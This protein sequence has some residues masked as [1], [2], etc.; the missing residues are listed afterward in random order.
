[1]VVLV[2]TESVTPDFVVVIDPQAIEREFTTT[3][4]SFVVMV[5]SAH[6]APVVKE[7]ESTAM[8][9]A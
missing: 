4:A 3:E 8:D 9:P 1:M 5:S 7:M 2:A 6:A